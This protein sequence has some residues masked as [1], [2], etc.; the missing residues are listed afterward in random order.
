[1]Y[2]T[3]VLCGLMLVVGIRIVI[4]YNALTEDNRMLEIVTCL[5]NH[6]PLPADATELVMRL[7]W[8]SVIM[9]CLLMGWCCVTS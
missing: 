9:A 6:T 8:D 1:M 4:S 2:K 5:D 7:L 3:G